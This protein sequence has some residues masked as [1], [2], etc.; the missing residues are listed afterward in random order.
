MTEKH[1]RLNSE[2]GAIA[3][4]IL[5]VALAVRGWRKLVMAGS[6]IGY[7]LWYQSAAK[8]AAG[9]PQSVS[10]VMDAQITAFSEAVGDWAVSHPDIA[11]SLIPLLLTVYLAR[12]WTMIEP[13]LLAWFEA[14][15]R[16]KAVQ[17][18]ALAAAAGVYWWALT[19][20]YVETANAGGY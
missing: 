9:T 2:Y 19:N 18:G 6:A 14:P 17:L 15:L 4:S 5:A 16:T 7:G 3:L 1:E 13:F 20:G 11:M 10:D 8:V 12:K